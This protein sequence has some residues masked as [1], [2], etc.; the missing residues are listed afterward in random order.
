MEHASTFSHC[1]CYHN[2][3]LIRSSQAQ[4]R[5]GA[6]IVP[7]II[8]SDK[9]QLTLFRNKTAYPVYL[10]IGNIPK[11]IRRKPSRR[12]QILLAYLP[13]TRLQNI[14]SPTSRRRALG[15]LFHA[16]MTRILA[17]LKDA[18]VHGIN[19]ATGD[20]NVHRTHPIFATFVGDYPEQILVTCLKN[21]DCPTCPI[22]PEDLGSGNI[23]APRDL[24][25]ILKALDA[26]DSHPTEFARACL[27]AGIK[28]IFHPFWED[29]PYVNIYRSITPDI[30]HQLYQGLISTLR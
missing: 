11:E 14:S 22:P 9:T 4:L 28:P 13:T 20:G 25:L 16:C 7:V 15:N 8:S 1:Q 18:G 23:E 27:D 17:P 24:A 2:Q 5:D 26:V 10:T 3:K 19:M 30:L 21:G 29:L 12:A 6:T